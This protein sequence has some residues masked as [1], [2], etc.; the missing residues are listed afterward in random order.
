[1]PTWKWWNITPEPFFL[2]EE[3]LLC[4]WLSKGELNRSLSPALL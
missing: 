4:P 3:A 2:E 1:M